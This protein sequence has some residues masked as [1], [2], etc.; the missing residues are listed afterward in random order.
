M[1]HCVGVALGC[2]W[3]SVTFGTWNQRQSLRGLVHDVGKVA[4]IHF[5]AMSFSKEL[6][7][8]KEKMTSR[9]G[10]CEKFAK[11]EVLGSLIAESGNAFEL[12]QS[13]R[14]H[15]RIS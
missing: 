1:K 14:W 5:D 11:H 15:H 7:S 8:A 10:S 6:L 3:P 4:K 9:N 13:I 2:H 12:S